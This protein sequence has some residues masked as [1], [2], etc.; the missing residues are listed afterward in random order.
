MKPKE[1][2]IKYIDK[3]GEYLNLLGQLGVLEVSE[4][5]DMEHYHEIETR[6][7]EAEREMLGISRMFIESFIY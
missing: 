5:V 4:N 2:L 1:L 3:K 7:L 6:T